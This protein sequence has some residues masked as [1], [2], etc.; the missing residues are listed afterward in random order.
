MKN[1]TGNAKNSPFNK[2]AKIGKPWYPNS[3][4][5]K[6]VLGLPDPDPYLVARIWI[7]QQAK[8]IRKNLD[9]YSFLTSL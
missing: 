6:T 8:N 3:L 9:F 1:K 2:A 5:H 7:Q 4:K